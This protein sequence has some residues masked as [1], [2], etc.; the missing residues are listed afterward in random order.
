MTTMMSQMTGVR[1][2]YSAVCSGA[3]KKTLKLGITSLC[4]RN[5]PVTAQM[6]SNLVT[7]KML[8]FPFDDVIIR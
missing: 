5:S 2:V 7:R 3:D 1:I 4:E 8:N 6:A